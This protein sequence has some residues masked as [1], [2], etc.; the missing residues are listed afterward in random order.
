MVPLLKRGPICP[1]GIP[2]FG[3]VT[4]VGLLRQ[5]LAD[6]TEKTAKEF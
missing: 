6:G 1:E 3:S 5:R 4:V 2:W